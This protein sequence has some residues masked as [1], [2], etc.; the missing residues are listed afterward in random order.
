MEVGLILEPHLFIS[1]MVHI[2]IMQPLLQT[3]LAVDATLKIC[4]IVGC[5]CPGGQPCT[6]LKQSYFFVYR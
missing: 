4:A 6:R 3:L 2:T 1:K 5:Y